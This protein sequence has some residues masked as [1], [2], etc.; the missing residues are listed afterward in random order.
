LLSFALFAVF[1]LPAIYSYITVLPYYARN[2]G[3]VQASYTNAGFTFTSWLSFIFPFATAVN[4]HMFGTDASMRNGFFSIAGFICVICCIKKATPLVKVLLVTAGIM[5]LLSL[6]GGIKV[7]IYNNLPLLKYIRYNGEFRVFAIVCFSII[8]GFGLQRL[9]AEA[10]YAR[11]AAYIFKV[12]LAFGIGV[13]IVA[14]ITGYGSILATL[15][16]IAVPAGVTDRIKTFL[17]QGSFALFMCISAL[18]AAI[19]CLLSI[20]TLKTGNLNYTCR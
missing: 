3:A 8:A 2:N 15:H 20:R 10:K 13:L 6:G 14:G 4:Q 1:Y 19:I 16:K 18:L 9:A 5:L 12:V 7:F 17:Q 11:L